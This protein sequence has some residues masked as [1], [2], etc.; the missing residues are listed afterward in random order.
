MRVFVTGASGHIGSAVVPELLEAGHR[1]L[2]LA[3]SE[4]AV[5]EL[6]A[7]GAEVHLGDLDDLEGLAAAAAS[8]DGVIHLAFKH[9]LNDIVRAAVF[10]LRAVE[11]MGAALEGSDKPFVVTSGTLLLAFAALGRPGTEL[12]FLEGGPRIDSDNTAVA[13]AERGVRSSVVRLSPLVHS[14]LDHHGFTHRLIDTAAR[15]ASRPLSETAPTGGPRSTPSTSQSSTAWPSK[16]HRQDHGSMG[17]TTKA[18]RSSTSPRSSV[19]TWTCRRSRSTP[20]RWTS[21]SGSWLPSW[22]STTPLPAL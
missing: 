9:D 4:L 18:C 15:R 2:G 17:S 22:R 21:T 19:T 6:T 16:P 20:P 8:A 5:A 13:Y 1:V 12:D 14:F 10:D 3:R 7:L 11:T